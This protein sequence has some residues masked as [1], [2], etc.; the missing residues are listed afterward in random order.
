MKYL[1]LVK[2]KV[3]LKYLKK[4]NSAFMRDI[5]NKQLNPICLSTLRI[6]TQS[7]QVR[8]TPGGHLR[9]DNWQ[10]DHSRVHHTWRPQAPGDLV[11]QREG[12]RC[13]Q[14]VLPGFGS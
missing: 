10:E 1:F 8:E 14:R 3:F 6:Q 5:G 12:H 9:Q 4:R 11:P 2:F 13:H 7:S